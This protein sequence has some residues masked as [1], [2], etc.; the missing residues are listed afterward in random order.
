MRA[1]RV[2]CQRLEQPL[3]LAQAG[4]REV[5]N[6]AAGLTVRSTPAVDDVRMDEPLVSLGRFGRQTVM[7]AGWR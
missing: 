6:D 1:D 5:A 7:P 2:A 4:G 3:L